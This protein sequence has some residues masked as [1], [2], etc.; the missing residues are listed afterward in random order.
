MVPADVAFINT[1]LRRP[2]PAVQL[3]VIEVVPTEENEMADTCVIG[4]GMKVTSS[5]LRISEF[6]PPE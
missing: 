6:D 2:L 1:A 3:T 4:C 5:Q